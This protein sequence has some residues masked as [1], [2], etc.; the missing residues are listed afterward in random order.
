LIASN[1]PILKGLKMNQALSKRTFLG[2][3]AAAPIALAALKDFRFSA[4]A[5]AAA[6]TTS[7]ATAGPFVLPELPYTVRALEK[8]IDAQ[9]MT[10]HHGKHH[11]AYIDNLNKEVASNENLSGKTLEEILGSV[12]KFSPAVRNNAGGHWNHS[13]FWQIMAS[14]PSEPSEELKAAIDAKFGSMDEFKK[15][16]EEAGTKQFGSGWAWLLVNKKG[17]LEITATPNQDNPLMD[18]AKV[19]G[20]PILG[21]DVWEHAYYLRYQNKRADYLKAWW[22]IVNWTKVSEHYAAAKSA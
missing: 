16:F 7:A 11:Q 12:S 6:P 2:Y 15:K 10:I 8:V 18:D 20:T 3:L 19:K 17:E 4:P 5:Y 14:K 1:R 13:F 21:N 22:G 9:T